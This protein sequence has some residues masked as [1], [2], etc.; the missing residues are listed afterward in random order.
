MSDKEKDDYALKRTQNGHNKHIR[1]EVTCKENG[2]YLS[3]MVSLLTQ[4]SI[5][6]Y[7]LLRLIQRTI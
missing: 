6:T 7:F 4:N 5:K 1:H 2:D 3:E